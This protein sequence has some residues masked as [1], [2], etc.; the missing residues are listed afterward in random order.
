MGQAEHG[1]ELLL[2]LQLGGAVHL[3]SRETGAERGHERSR[4]LALHGWGGVAPLAKHS[5]PLPPLLLQQL[6]AV[7]ACGQTEHAQELQ[8]LCARGGMRESEE[9]SN[10]SD[11]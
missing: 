11:R 1:E 4:P 3:L 5:P 9:P 10:A 2:V 7:G 8:L 6:V